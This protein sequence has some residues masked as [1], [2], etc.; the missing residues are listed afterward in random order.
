VIPSVPFKQEWL[1]AGGKKQRS[2]SKCKEIKEAREEVTVGPTGQNVQC[3]ALPIQLVNCKTLRALRRNS[4]SSLYQQ[5]QPF[6]L[7][8][9]NWTCLSL[10]KFVYQCGLAAHTEAGTISRQ[11]VEHLSTWRE[12]EREVSGDRSC[13]I[14]GK[15]FLCLAIHFIF[16]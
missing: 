12:L 2:K 16:A 1:Q 14:Q 3:S 5:S 13:Q 4:M 15:V 11:K 9:S 10:N 7:K 6:L 8:R